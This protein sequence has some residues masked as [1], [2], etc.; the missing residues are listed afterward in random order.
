MQL[1]RKGEAALDAWS[2]A[3]LASGVGLG[4]VGLATIWALVA[5]VAF[6]VVEGGLRRIK[7]TQRSS[8]L[9]EHESW[10]NIAADIVVG[11]SGFF[12]GRAAH[13]WIAA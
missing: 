11:A 10:S 6:E 1:A 2:L 12:L 7:T 4:L 13:L 5:I 8:G 9:F 3:H